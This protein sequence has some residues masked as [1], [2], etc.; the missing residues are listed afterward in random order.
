MVHVVDMKSVLV[1]KTGI[2]VSTI[3][4]GGTSDITTT[5]ERP[6]HDT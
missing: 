6:Q 5:Q 1:L 3:A 2:Q 4:L